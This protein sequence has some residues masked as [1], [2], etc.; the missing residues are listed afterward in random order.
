LIN[1]L[2]NQMING[3]MMM[4]IINSSSTLIN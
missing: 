3:L 2:I 4:F 1:R